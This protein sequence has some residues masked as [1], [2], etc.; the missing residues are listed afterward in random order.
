M[1]SSL[2]I[3]LRAPGVFLYPDT[4]LQT[5]TGVRMDV[6]AFCGVAPRGPARV[7]VVNEQWPD[8]VPQVEAGRPI[9][10]TQAF[11]VESFTE[12]Q[13]LYG[14]FE[15]P[16]LLPFAVASFFEQGGQRAYVA[17]IVHDYG[18]G[19]PGNKMR[20]ASGVVPGVSTPAAG[21]ILLRASNEGSWGNLLQV[22]LSFQASPVFFESA[23]I[24]DL[25]VDGST[26][27][28]EGDLL[29]LTFADGSRALRIVSDKV[30]QPRP[31]AAGYEVQVI[32]ASPAP[33]VAQR[34]EIVV[35]TLDIDD[36]V[37]NTEM[38]NGLGLSSEH[39]R[40]MATVI[41]NESALIFPDASWSSLAVIPDTVSLDTVPALDNQFQ[42]GADGWADIT[43]DDFFD[44]NWDPT[45]ED[46]GQGVQCL[47]ELSDLTILVVPDLYSPA[48]L[49]YVDNILDPVSLAGPDFARC[50]DVP[51]QVRQGTSS[52]DLA[53]LRL[54]PLDPGDLETITALQRQVVVFADAVEQF[55]VL[56]D[57]PPGLTQQAIIQWRG[58][59]NS[60]YTACYYP[61]L[62]VT[63]RDGP[64]SVIQK[65]PP[66]APAAGIIAA[67][68]IQFGVPTG[69][70]NVLAAQ[71]VD[72]TDV[73]TPTR[74][75]Q[76][77]PLG[78]N[79]YLRD[80]DGVRLTAARTLSRDPQYRQ[81][82]VRRLI[83]LLRLSL[84]QQMQ[85]AVFEPNNAALRLQIRLLLQNFL[86]A[87]F[88]QGAFAGATEAESYFVRCDDTN[89]P[90]YITDAGMLI[91][92]IGVAPSEPIEFIFVRISRGGDGT[93][94][95]L[96]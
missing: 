47:A 21:P 90:P 85:W 49:T 67:T 57:V 61:W 45:S 34:A 43:P 30:S 19:N 8:D 77:H 27:I 1:V 11:A 87:L 46:P 65:I 36:G 40:W 96:G 73:V 41:C 28:V 56:L 17:R 23:T 86:R 76:L 14:G 95:V 80:R 63:R 10:R 16:G 62:W 48:P 66:S 7:P 25:V 81:L 22:Q 24:T 26:E 58:A 64:Q 69:P 29:R 84:Y 12:Y 33:S 37:G 91:A 68:V 94:S 88:N 55:V 75:D 60:T 70:A 72:V 54:D 52:Y 89:N 53:G 92:E 5:L 20:V 9:N 83:T 93:L 18:P 32:F 71:V 74:H 15:G 2:A 38:L 6:S 31:N 42:W 35:G 4:P 13:R 59:F 78:V 50:V 3:P 79:V 44:P 82:S 39:P 51:L